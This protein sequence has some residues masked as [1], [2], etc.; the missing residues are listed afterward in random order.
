M[1]LVC[2]FSVVIVFVLNR[3]RG[4]YGLGLVCCSGI[5]I[6]FNGVLYGVLGGDLLILRFVIVIL[7]LICLRRVFYLE[8]WYVGIFLLACL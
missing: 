8:V 3:I 1:L 6:L 5:Q 2:R 4:L 7:K